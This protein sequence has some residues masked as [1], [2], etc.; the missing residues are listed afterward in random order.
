MNENKDISITNIQDVKTIT[1]PWGYE[2]LIAD[3]SPDFKYALK[4]IL[5][6][7]NYSSSIQ[8]HEFK[9]ET[10]YVKSGNGLLYYN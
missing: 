5:I 2:K 3:G 6:R 4:E 9:Q 8:F 10:T 1:K 7:S